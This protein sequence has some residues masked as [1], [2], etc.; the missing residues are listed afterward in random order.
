MLELSALEAI[1]GD[2][3]V[4]VRAPLVSGLKPVAEIA[5]EGGI[6]LTL[7][8]DETHKFSLTLYHGADT[9]YPI[10]DP[11]LL[12][13]ACDWL[14]AACVAIFFFFFFF[15]FFFLSVPDFA[16]RSILTIVS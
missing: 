16:V 10:M 7:E 5:S 13:V 15:F 1:L 9:S 14:D 2:G 11:P 4:A 3:K 6:V 8:A 12:A